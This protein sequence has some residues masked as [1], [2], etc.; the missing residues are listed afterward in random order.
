MDWPINTSSAPIIANAFRVRPGITI[1]RAFQAATRPGS[2]SLKLIESPD[3]AACQSPV[4]LTG[5]SQ[6]RASVPF[7]MSPPEDQEDHSDA[8]DDSDDGEQSKDGAGRKT[9]TIR[10]SRACITCRRMKT[11]CEIDEALGSACKLCIRTRRQCI[12]QDIPRRRK[13][14]T[15]ERVADLE[16]KINALTALLAAKESGAASTTDSDS[17]PPQLRPDLDPLPIS[18]ESLMAEALSR[19]LLDWETARTAFDR[20]KNDMSHYLPFVVFPGTMEA[21]T[22]KEQQPL[23]F[24]AIVTVGLS[25]MKSKADSELCDMLVKDLAFRIMYK[26]ERSLELVQTL[27]VHITYY[28]RALQ[29]RDLNFNQMTHIA[30]TMATDIGLGRRPHKANSLQRNDPHQLESLAARRAW[31]G[32][33]YMATR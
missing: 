25:R 23:L 29:M 13:R 9:K 15:T 31:L 8:S 11:R 7:E 16:Q 22:L 26:G 14:K 30:S 1:R 27:L 18:E 6:F 4:T 10:S 3:N 32:C 33:Y 12:M 24:F 20:Y 17:L 21:S 5:M 2:P 28:S 19:G